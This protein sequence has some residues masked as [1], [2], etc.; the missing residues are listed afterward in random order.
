[1]KTVPLGRS[2]LR[3]PCLGLGAV[4]FGREIDEP[5]SWDILDYA[6]AHGVN[7]IDT[8]EAYGGGNARQSR[9]KAYKVDDVREMSDEMHSSEKIVGRWM[10]ARQSRDRVMICT[11]FNTGGTR[12]Q[13][14]HSLRDSLTRLQTDRV[15]IYML[16][17]SFPNVAIRET[18]EALTAEV[19]AGRI[20]T[21]GCSNFSAAQLREAQQ[22][23]ELHGLARMNSTQPSF[24]LA[25]AGAR[26]DLL[27]YCQQEEIATIT[28][29]PLAAGFLS[30]KYSSGGSIPK[31]TRF[32]ISP[33]HIDVYFSEQNFRVVKNLRALSIETG[34]PMTKLAMAWVIQHPG[35]SAVL[36]GARQ[37]SHLDNALAAS[38][39]PLDPALIARMSAWLEVKLA[40]E[41]ATSSK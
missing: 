40:A 10:K 3:I 39:H 14:K 29:S 25:E 16:H 17:C 28:Y 36:V 18:L 15:D 34:E 21:I 5:S 8:A 32:D 11:K 1:M 19:Q 7:L 12:D 4:P 24:S 37:R 27:P 33:A 41:D 9:Q 26:H 31:G 6:I 22:T 2:P 35:V 30:G 23:A 13:V 20:R 38:A